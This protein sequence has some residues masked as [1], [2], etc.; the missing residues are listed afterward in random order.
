MS[1]GAETDW[2]VETVSLLV[3]AGADLTLEDDNQ[4]TVMTQAATQCGPRVIGVLAEAGAPIDRR[5]GSGLSPLGLAL[6]MKKLDAA[7]ALIDHG[8]RLT[9]QEQQMLSSSA[10]DERSAALIRKA[11]GS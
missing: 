9:E 5:N 3:A 8:A 11:S 1:Q 10:S 7:E 2:L 6:I 4:N